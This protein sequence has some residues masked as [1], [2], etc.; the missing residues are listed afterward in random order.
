MS[1]I[2]D[3]TSTTILGH[4]CRDENFLDIPIDIQNPWNVY[5]KMKHYS[6]LWL[7][8][9]PNELIWIKAK[10]GSYTTKLGYQ[11]LITKPLEVEAKWW[12]KSI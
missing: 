5:I 7:S 6:H 11:V 10:H 1:Q 3:P 2:T 9:R 12:L 8:N 4:G